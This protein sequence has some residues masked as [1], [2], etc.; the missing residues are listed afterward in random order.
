[1]KGYQA[2]IDAANQYTGQNY[3]EK[4]R[5]FLALR[6]DIGRIDADGKARII[7]SLGGAEALKQFIKS[8]DDWN[9]VHLVVRGN[10]MI[11]LING[12]VM[13]VTV[14][15][16]PA[17]RKFDGLLGMQVHVGGPMKVEY[18]NIRLKQSTPELKP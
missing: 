7:G 14:D 10:V 1:L 11:H 18:R 6:G 5:T 3:E 8:G 15:D 12:H 17:H 16:D 13:S 9:A 4:G 2:D